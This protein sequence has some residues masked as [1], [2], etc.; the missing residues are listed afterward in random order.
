MPLW[1]NILL[2]L[3]VIVGRIVARLYGVFTEIESELTAAQAVVQMGLTAVA[4]FHTPD[5][6]RIKGTGDGAAPPAA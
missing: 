3:L 2:Q 6:R 5:G 4:A 1:V